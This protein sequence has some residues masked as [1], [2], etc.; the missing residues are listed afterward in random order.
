MNKD[1]VRKEIEHLMPDFDIRTDKSDVVRVFWRGR[2]SGIRQTDEGIEVL[3]GLRPAPGTL[4]FLPWPR[5]REI[6][7]N[8]REAATKLVHWL[9]RVD[10]TDFDSPDAWKS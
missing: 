6:A 3:I 10:A 1:L 8:E 4:D 2:D 5:I 9:T 7:F